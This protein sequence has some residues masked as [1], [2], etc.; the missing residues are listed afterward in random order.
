[1]IEGRRGKSKLQEGKTSMNGNNREDYFN[2]YLDER[3][4]GIEGSIG[5]M[6]EAV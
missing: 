2:Q 1:M 4:K 5:R 6:Q 3:F